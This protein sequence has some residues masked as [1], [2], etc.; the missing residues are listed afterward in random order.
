MKYL[1]A[2]FFLASS[3]VCFG[4]GRDRFEKGGDKGSTEQ[5][6]EKDQQPTKQK[7]EASG[8]ES[9]L[10]K[11]VFGGNASLAF[12]TN[13]L[14]FLSPTVGYRVTDKLILGTGVIYQYLSLA[15]RDQQGNLIRGAFKSQTIGPLF[16]GAYSV[17][18]FLYTGVQFEYL[19]HDAP[20]LD[21]NGVFIDSERIWSPV[22]FLELGYT[23]QIGERGMLRLGIRY[24]VLHQG[25]RAPYA[26]PFFPVIGVF[27]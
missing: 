13:T 6:E 25:I 2:L 11:L 4:Q 10:D 21:R 8:K 20:I 3:V 5:Q 24:N 16:Y 17:T 14:V 23:Q 12:G 22:L 9:L 18:D 26:S 7:L 19:R 15:G 27:F 1:F